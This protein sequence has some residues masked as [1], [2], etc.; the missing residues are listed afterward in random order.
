MVPHLAASRG[1]GLKCPGEWRAGSL[2]RATIFVALLALSSCAGQLPK[3]QVS[4]EPL[5]KET[6]QKEPNPMP[7]FIYRP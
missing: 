2:S 1:K 6:Q 7:I 4:Q 5:E 3:P